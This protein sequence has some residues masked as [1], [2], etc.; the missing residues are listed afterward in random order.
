METVS[1]TFKTSDVGEVTFDNVSCVEY[2][3]SRSDLKKVEGAALNTHMFETDY[4]LYH[5]TGKDLNVTFSS[6][7][8]FCIKVQCTTLP[9]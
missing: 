5:I 3:T 2:G 4:N 6:R 8:I 1:I 7:K 9:F